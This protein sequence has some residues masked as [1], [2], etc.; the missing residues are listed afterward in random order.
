MCEPTG[1][2]RRPH[3]RPCTTA[4]SG[5]R[6]P[7]RSWSP[8]SRST[9]DGTSSRTGWPAPGSRKVV[10]RG[11]TKWLS[12]MKPAPWTYWKT[13]D[14]HAGQ[15]KGDI[16]KRP[17]GT[18]FPGNPFLQEAFSPSGSEILF[19]LPNGLQAYMLVD[20]QGRRVDV[21]ASDVATDPLQASGTPALVNGLS[22]LA[23]HRRGV[24]SLKDEVRG[25]SNVV[26][27]AKAKVERIYTVPSEMDKLLARDE[28]RFVAAQARAMAPFLKPVGGE[29]PDILDV[30]EPVW[31]LVRRFAKNLVIEDVAGELGV[32]DLSAIRAKIREDPGLRKLE[33][34]LVGK[35]V[36][37]DVW[38]DS[39]DQMAIKLGLGTSHRS[40]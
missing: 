20:A 18:D 33:P 39:F 17:L 30:P 22:C 31:A 26:G 40:F 23:C 37:R 9:L 16:F 29:A 19:Q 28:G 2:S 25:V 7:L 8:R 32:E 21:A 1:S 13:F 24:F 10:S 34:L 15:E 3:T 14:F 38:Q 36:T 11:R 4:S 12:D 35:S 27:R 5:S 6:I